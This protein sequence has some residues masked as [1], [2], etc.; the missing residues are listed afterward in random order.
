MPGRPSHAV[1]FVELNWQL[2][3]PR[4]SVIASIMMGEE[5]F[6]DLAE[7]PLFLEWEW[8]KICELLAL[9][10]RQAAVLQG[11]LHG[12][13]DENIAKRLGV[14]PPTVRSHFQ[15]MFR[16]LDVPDRTGLVVA[17]F[18]IFRGA[19]MPQSVRES[20]GKIAV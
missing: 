15:R 14:T 17:V 13:D 7:G 8:L 12:I 20:R 6:R 18:K 9:T 4:L 19:I 3:L 2:T 1:I 5:S 11:L 10:E 16:L